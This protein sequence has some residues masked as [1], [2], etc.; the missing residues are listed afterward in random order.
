MIAQLFKEM[1]GVSIPVHDPKTS[2]RWYKEKLGCK[3]IY[4]ENQGARLRVEN[5]PQVIICLVYTSKDEKT[6]K[7]KGESFYYFQSENI[8]ETYKLLV[9]RGVKVYPINYKENKKFFTFVD[10]DGNQL[11][12][13]Q[14]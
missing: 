7:R 5:D 2:A 4:F 6:T 11:G 9:D 13:Y 10:L 1:E 3:L 12:V 14:I 8:E